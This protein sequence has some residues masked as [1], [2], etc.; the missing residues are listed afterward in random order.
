MKDQLLSFII[1]SDFGIF[2]KPDVNENY[3][4]YEF[5]PKPSL[6]GIL[7]S[8][9]GFK[10]YSQGSSIPE[11]YKK[12]SDLRI[13]IQ[14]M[15]KKSESSA[16]FKAK[17]FVSLKKPR[18]KFFVK[19][20][21]YHGYG[22]YEASGNLIIQEQLL[23]KPSFRIFLYKGNC[24]NSIYEKIKGNLEN[25]Y[26]TYGLYMGKNDFPL[27]FIYETEYIFKKPSQHIIGISSIFRK[28]IIEDISMYKGL[29]EKKTATYKI[30]HNY[31]YALSHGQYL[32]TSM[33]YSNAKFIINEEI[34]KETDSLICEVNGENVFLF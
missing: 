19:Y 7:G 9:I 20:I 24:S 14:P 28:D 26:S 12:L 2:K 29:G 18:N 34:L 11:F 6:L 23:Y 30:F 27:S 31:P 4:T 5:I 17:D 22:S 21:N 3:L 13:G 8:L 1:F 10:G 15:I 32:Y 25:N 33:L 16:P